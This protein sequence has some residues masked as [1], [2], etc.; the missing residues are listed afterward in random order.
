MNDYVKKL[1]AD[2][3]KF[4][5]NENF[6]PNNDFEADAY[7]RSL[8]KIDKNNTVTIHLNEPVIKNGEVCEKISLN[9]HNYLDAFFPKI[10]HQLNIKERLNAVVFAFDDCVQSHTELVKN[11]PRLIISFS[12]PD[13]LYGMQDNQKDE[14]IVQMGLRRLTTRDLDPMEVL[15]TIHH[16]IYHCKQC[17]MR[18]RIIDKIKSDKKRNITKHNLSD[19]ELSIL[20]NTDSDIF[21]QYKGDIEFFNYEKFFKSRFGETHPD[22]KYASYFQSLKDDKEW[23]YLLKICYYVDAYETGAFDKETHLANKINKYF[24]AT[25][26]DSNKD[27]NFISAQQIALNLMKKLNTYYGFKFKPSDIDEFRKISQMTSND[28]K[29]IYSNM[30]FGRNWLFDLRIDSVDW[31]CLKKLMDIRKDKCVKHKTSTKLVNK[32]KKDRLKSID[33]MPY[34]A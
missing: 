12:L 6:E 17:E 31:L 4:F 19:Y 9:K 22:Y 28:P 27:Y 8:Y 16:E 14:L 25:F 7:I 15:S 20:N 5:Q 33:E 26:Q 23:H 32:L 29:K 18:K 2:F 11:N 21:L 24:K 10:W 34:I 13:E 1:S 30:F 3:Q